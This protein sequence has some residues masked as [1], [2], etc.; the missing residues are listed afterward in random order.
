MYAEN[1]MNNYAARKIPEIF[2]QVSSTSTGN[3]YLG[4]LGT[5]AGPVALQKTKVLLVIRYL[6]SNSIL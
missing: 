4:Q 5:I 2:L 6:I 3:R 1:A